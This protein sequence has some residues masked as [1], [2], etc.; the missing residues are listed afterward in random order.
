MSID[1]MRAKKA[2][3]VCSTPDEGSATVTAVPWN[4]SVTTSASRTMS[5]RA[6]AR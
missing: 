6:A 1:V 4:G 3:I 5:E 2:I